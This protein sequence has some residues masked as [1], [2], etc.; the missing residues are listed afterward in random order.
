M[1]FFIKEKS[2]DIQ[3]ETMSDKPVITKDKVVSLFESKFIK[4]YDLQYEEGKHYYDATRRSAEDLTA[5]K[6][7]E[8]FKKMLPDAVSCAVVLRQKDREP[9]LLMTKEYRYPTGQFLLSPPA[10]LLDP[11]DALAAEPVLETAKRE[12]HE[13]TGLTV[14][15]TDR[16]AV[17]N[18]LL[19][20]T[21]GMTDE[22]NALVLAVIDTDDTA[23]L[24]TDG[25]VGAEKFDGF[26]LINK[27]D[28]RRIL[29]RGRDDEDIFYSVYTWAVLMYF[30]SDMWKAEIAD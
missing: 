27:E 26:V 22:S 15:D 16:M 7:D 5:V 14:K 19:F 20:S 3:E 25:N 18:P 29:R 10:G 6:A 4:V 21:P 8:E 2:Q 12:I 28:A 17:I 13:E 11:E 30:A 23:E 9:V 1:L 24:N